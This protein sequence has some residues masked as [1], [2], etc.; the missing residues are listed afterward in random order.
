MRD[1]LWWK[2]SLDTAL[3]IALVVFAF[4]ALWKD[5]GE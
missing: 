1:P 3:L 2:D 5:G 4:W